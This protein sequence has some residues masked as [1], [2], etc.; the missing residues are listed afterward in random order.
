MKTLFKDLGYGFRMLRRSPAFAAVAIL[1]LALGIGVTTAVFSVVNA[2]LLRPLPFTHQERLTVLW[3]SAKKRQFGQIETSYANFRDW[4]EQNRVFSQ[5]AALNSSNAGMN[6]TGVGEPRQVDAAPVSY[7]FFTTLGVRPL[8]GRTFLSEDDRLGSQ[9]VA[10]LSY[11]MWRE[12]LGGDPRILGRQLRLDGQSYTVVGVMPGVFK[13][14]NGA[15]LWV[16]LVPYLGPEGTELRIYRVL[17]AIGRLR[18]GVSLE[19]ASAEMQVIGDRLEARYP[20]FNEGFT[21]WV[22]P[23]ANEIVGDSRP[24]L[25]ILLSGAVFLLLIAVA[26]VANLLLA[27]TLER[28][29]EIGVR[30]AL[31]ADRGR[32]MRQLLTEGIALGLLGA[33]CGLLLALLGIGLLRAVAPSSIPRID[34]VQLDFPTLLFT[35]GVF[36][37]AVFVFGAAPA[38]EA[39]RGDLHEPLKEGGKRSFG[40]ARSNRL[41][42]LLVRS[43]ISLALVLLIGAGLM[44]QSMLQLKRID[45]GFAKENVLTARIRLPEKTYPDARQRQRFFDRLRERAE[46]LPG[47]TSA[48]TV[49]TRPLDTSVVWEMPIAREGQSWDELLKNPLT[50]FQAISPGYFR[51]MKIRLIKGR[52]F[53]EHDTEEAPLVAIV[54]KGLA[55]HY[56][57]GQDPIGKRVRRIF[58]DQVTPWIT[59]I[60]VADDVR[61]RGWDRVMPDFYLPAPQNPLAQYMPYQDLVVRTSADPLSLARPLRQAVYSIDRNQA[62]A[63]I[64]T[65]DSLVDRSL[66]GPRFTLLLMGI[67][68]ALALCLAAVGIYGLLSYMVSQRSREIGLRMALGARKQQILRMVLAQGLKLVASGLL[69]GLVAAL[70]LTRFMANLL[71]GVSALDPLTFITVPIFLAGVALLA[72]SLPA[73]RA[74]RSDP[75][76]VLRYD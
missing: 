57:P 30:A 7:N 39:G 4:R 31:G 49:L 32:V 19:R 45:P 17:K 16:P 6:L 76:K 37:A 15:Q 9:R 3:E 14:P 65:L 40:S 72:T 60:G 8:L 34:E 48:A 23:L 56:W 70:F 73:L 25:L 61:Y 2:V 38:L 33:G 68:G 43:E 1:T 54:S 69:L 11:A 67:F 44:V 35:L 59:I 29:H 50:N 13:Y 55:A 74:I 28:R 26:N 66:A 22:G 41:R 12:Q 71:Y 62:I 46:A 21:A 47:V 64:M 24:T 10:V 5:L 20:K 75:I 36:V 52:D 42:R 51:T 18:P 27:R 53:D 58:S 63:S